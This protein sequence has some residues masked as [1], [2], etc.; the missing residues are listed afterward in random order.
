MAVETEI[1][2]QTHAQPKLVKSRSGRRPSLS[3]QEAPINAMTNDEQDMPRVMFNF[4]VVSW[5]PAVL[6]T[7]SWK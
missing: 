4:V 6:R 3:T 2:I 1:P 5:I 7:A